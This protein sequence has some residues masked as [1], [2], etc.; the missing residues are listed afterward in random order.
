MTDDVIF[1]EMLTILLLDSSQGIVERLTIGGAYSSGHFEDLRVSHRSA[2]FRF[3]GDT[4]WTV[5]VSPS[6]TFKLPFSDPRGVSRA[7]GLRK[8]IDISA[9]PAPASFRSSR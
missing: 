9:T 3:I 8:Y 7:M 2:S 5:K 4:T 1:E 6:P